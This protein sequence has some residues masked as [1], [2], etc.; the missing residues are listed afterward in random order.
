MGPYPI[1]FSR[2]SASA[3]SP[4]QSARFSLPPFIR[5]GGGKEIRTP[6]IQLA[7]LALYQLS[8]TPGSSGQFSLPRQALSPEKEEVKTNSHAAHQNSHAAL[9]VRRFRKPLTGHSSAVLT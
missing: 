7:K 2:P 9:K 5:N 8:Y 4:S 6:D 3:G 1:R